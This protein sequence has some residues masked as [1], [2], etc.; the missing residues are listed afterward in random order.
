MHP[1]NERMLAMAE[2][3]D[4]F[5]HFNLDVSE[6]LPEWARLRWQEILKGGKKEEKQNERAGDN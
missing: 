4:P 1:F 3:N 6:P 5:V 2:A